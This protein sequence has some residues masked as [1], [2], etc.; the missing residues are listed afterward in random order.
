MS[1]SQSSLETKRRKLENE[2]NNSNEEK[3]VSSQTDFSKPGTSKQSDSCSMFPKKMDDSGQST[4]ARIKPK[5]VV[6]EKV[7]IPDPSV[8]IF[9]E[10]VTTCKKIKNDDQTEKIL[11]N[12]QKRYDQLDDNF[13]QD[14]DFRIFLRQ[15]LQKVS[16]G[17]NDKFYLYIQDVHNEIKR[18]IKKPKKA[19]VE[20]VNTKPDFRIKDSNAESPT[21]FTN[22][23]SLKDEEETSETSEN[24]AQSKEKSRRIKKLEETIQKCKKKIKELESREVDFSDE[25]DSAYLQEDRYKKKLVQLCQLYSNMVDD[26]ML[27]NEILKKQLRRKDIPDEMTGIPQLDDTLINIVNKSIKNMNKLKHIN[28][29]RAYPDFLKVPDYPEILQNIKNYNQEKNLKLTTSRMDVLGN[30]QNY[31]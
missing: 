19:K 30:C 25:E 7:S 3:K 24:S 8:D 20:E 12:L 31:L 26:K 9:Q 28:V 1:L 11:S 16:S 15:N 10:F 13:Q 6:K 2:K 22:V 5:L 17:H 27:K 14:E 29:P 18:R 23:N 4:S 21:K